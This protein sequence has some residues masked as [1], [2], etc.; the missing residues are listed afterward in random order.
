MTH[1]G[2]CFERRL[3]RKIRYA[4]LSGTLTAGTFFPLAFCRATKREVARR[5]E[6][7]ASAQSAEVLMKDGDAR[8]Y[9]SAPLASRCRQCSATPV[10]KTTYLREAQKS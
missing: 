5:G 1:A 9:A 6:I 8:H 4:K 10:R 7:P 3:P 2:V